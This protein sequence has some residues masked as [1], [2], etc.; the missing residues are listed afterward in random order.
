MAK[1]SVIARNVKRTK[2]VFRYSAL[3]E[4][5]KKKLLDAGLSDEEYFVAQR[6]LSKLPRNSSRVRVRNR[7]AITGRGRGFHGWFGLSRIQLRE[8]ASRGEIPGITKSSW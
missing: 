4:E 3:R 7:C 8:M 2:L 6:K 1:R 5:L